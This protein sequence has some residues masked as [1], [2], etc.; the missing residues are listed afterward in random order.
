MRRIS[1]DRDIILGIIVIV[2][3]LCF[4]SYLNFW[5]RRTIDRIAR[6]RLSSIRE[7]IKEFRHGR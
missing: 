1:M 4:I 5:S 2:G 6:K 3:G 7:I